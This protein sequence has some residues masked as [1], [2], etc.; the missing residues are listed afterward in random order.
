M[1]LE[2]FALAKKEGILRN[3]AFKN[4]GRNQM[5]W[6]AGLPARLMDNETAVSE[7]IAE[8]ENTFDLVMIADRFDESMILLK[9]L[10]CWDYRDVVNFKLNARKDSKKISL[11]A[12]AR[13]ALR[14]YLAADYL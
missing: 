9:D 11:T 14:E 13:A 2:T 3:R 1:D 12:E 4:L 10:L 8:M 6:D 7:K 5:L